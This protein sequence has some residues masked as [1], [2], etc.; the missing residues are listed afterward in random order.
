MLYTTFYI[1]QCVGREDQI[2]VT[3]KRCM[4]ERNR[5]ERV[6]SIIQ[7]WAT[8]ESS[9]TFAR[10]DKRFIHGVSCSARLPPTFLLRFL[11]NPFTDQCNP[12]NNCNIYFPK[13]F[14]QLPQSWYVAKYKQLRFLLNALH[15]DRL[16]FTSKLY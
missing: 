10:I 11:D 9:D 4:L 2:F 3:Y 7:S 5:F 6:R 14:T 13:L 15:K 16:L 8:R 1:W 12:V